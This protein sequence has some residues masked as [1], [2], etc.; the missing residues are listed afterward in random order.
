MEMVN[1]DDLRNAARRRLPRIF[2]DYIDGGAFS[3]ATM[4]ANRTDFERYRLKQRVLV[5]CAEP[6]LSTDVGTSE[7]T[8]N[9]DR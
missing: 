7:R 9:D 2:F 3:E 6:D 5:D 4:Q 8:E 1:V